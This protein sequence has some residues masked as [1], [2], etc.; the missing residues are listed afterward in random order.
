MYNCFHILFPSLTCWR[1]KIR[2]HTML[3]ICSSTSWSEK[4]SLP[5]HD[6][7]WLQYGCDLCF[8]GLYHLILTVCW[9]RERNKLLSKE[10]VERVLCWNVQE[11]SVIWKCQAWYELMEWVF[12]FSREHAMGMERKMMNCCLRNHPCF[13]TINMERKVPAFSRTFLPRTCIYKNVYSRKQ[14]KLCFSSIFS[15]SFKIQEQKIKY[16]SCR[17]HINTLANGKETP[18]KALIESKQ[19]RFFG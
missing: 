16:V 19:A 11:W 10:I 12:V 14:R 9:K 8:V 7:V 3:S 17:N 18:P 6:N 15:F 4:T 1:L 5:S 13:I 2:V